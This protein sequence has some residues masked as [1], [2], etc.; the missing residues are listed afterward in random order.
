MVRNSGSTSLC[1][2][3]IRVGHPEEM[4]RAGGVTRFR[5]LDFEKDSMSIFY[6]VRP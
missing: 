2:V 4:T 3:A 1:V 6:E 5:Q